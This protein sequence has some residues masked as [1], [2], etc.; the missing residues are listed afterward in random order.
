[1]EEEEDGMD[2]EMKEDASVEEGAWNFCGRR[3]EIYEIVIT[4]GR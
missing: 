3:K 1:M 2:E 4:L